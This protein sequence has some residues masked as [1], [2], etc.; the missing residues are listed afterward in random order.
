MNL[1]GRGHWVT[2]KLQGNTFPLLRILITEQPSVKSATAHPA[3]ISAPPPAT[4]QAPYLLPKFTGIGGQIKLS[5][6]DFM[7]EEI[8]AYTPSGEGEHLYF[9]VEKQG[10]SSEE[11]ARLLATALHIRPR[12]IGMAGRKDT[13]ALTRQWF[14]AHVPKGGMLQDF[15]HPSMRILAQSRHGNKLRT[16]HLQGNRFTITVHGVLLD[17]GW[18]EALNTLQSQGFPNYFGP[19]RFGGGG[20]N[21]ARGV[22]LLTDTA[23]RGWS[24]SQRLMV[25]AL[26]SVMFN[27]VLAIR[28]LEMGNLHDL[29]TGDLAWLHRNGASFA[30]TGENLESSR[31]RALEGEISPTGALPGHKAHYAEGTQGQWEAAIMDASGLAPEQFLR[32]PRRDSMPGTRRPL[33][34]FA[35]DIGHKVIST[36]PD[37]KLCLAFTLPPGAYATS[38]LRELMK[39]DDLSPTF[40]IN[41]AETRGDGH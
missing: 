1:C 40:Q 26:Q 5:P 12:D 9:Q 38:F 31:H 36:G 34:E 8:P 17:E 39:T 15:T 7:V 14:S 29:L 18:Q 25:N 33:R 41:H 10:I 20:G 32:T 21:P 37:A 19:Q 27:Q 2:T 28:L 6:E 11:A 22:A 3:D 16:G 30:I 23:K 4:V 13:Q 24:A 35:T